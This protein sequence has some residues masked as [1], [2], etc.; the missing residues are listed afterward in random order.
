M[1]RGLARRLSTKVRGSFPKKSALR[2]AGWWLPALSFKR[3]STTAA[4]FWDALWAPMGGTC[5]CSM[6]NSLLGS[7]SAR[8]LAEPRS[9][10][11]G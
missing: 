6:H 7:G 3:S 9:F 5:D 10:L 11:A 4:A 1:G 8:G 2:C